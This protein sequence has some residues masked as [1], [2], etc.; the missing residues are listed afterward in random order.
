MGMK[1]FPLG[2]ERNFSLG[3]IFHGYMF[4]QLLNDFMG[5]KDFFLVDWGIVRVL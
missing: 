4:E 3:I 1:F 5:M 2:M